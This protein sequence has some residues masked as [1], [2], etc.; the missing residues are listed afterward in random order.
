MYKVSA[1]LTNT[2]PNTLLQQLQQP[3]MVLLTV[4][5]GT[6]TVSLNNSAL[7]P[8]LPEF[9]Q[10]FT[11]GPLLAS[12]VVAGFMVAMGMTMPL[13]GYLGKKFGK[14][15]LYLVGLAIF[16]CSS[17]L[18]FFSHSMNGIIAARILQGIAGGLMIPLSLA[19][20]FSVYPKENRGK[21]T[22]IWG[23]AVMLAPAVGPLLGGVILEFSSWRALFLMNI[24]IGLLGLFIGILGLPPEPHRQDRAL[25]FDWKG[26]SLITI[27]IGS[28]MLFIVNMGHSYPADTVSF[29]TRLIADLTSYFNVDTRTQIMTWGAAHKNAG[30]YLLFAIS[31]IAF[32]AFIIGAKKSSNPLLNLGLFNYSSYRSS[33]VIAVVQAVGMFECLILLPL[34]VQSGLNLSPIWTGI[35]LLCTAVFASLFVRIGGHWL[36]TYGP[37]YTVTAGLVITAF[38]TISLGLF[39]EHLS[40]WLVI[41]LMSL[42][43]IGIGLSYMPVTTA[44]LNVIPEDMVTQGAAMNNISRRIVSSAA[45][46]LASLYLQQFH[47]SGLDKTLQISAINHVFLL[48]GLLI[49]ITIPLALSMPKTVKKT[50]NSVLPTKRTSTTR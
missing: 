3:R 43:G 9:M 4:L 17:A 44:G 11:V 19:L 35:S 22:G 32:W 14:K 30:L 25:P 15:A 36:D 38:A 7:N 24:P 34:L 12:W 40:L 23:A 48:T 41:V 39:N 42:R 5:L 47:T 2:L 50:S 13:T 18:G 29:S 49:F 8:A 10:V 1:V 46:V 21:V 37:K 27:A 20:I 16:L 33:V 6:T 31:I 26:F 45:I 28:M